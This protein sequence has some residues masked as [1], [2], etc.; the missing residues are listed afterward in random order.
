MVLGVFGSAKAK[1]NANSNSS[2]QSKAAT[3]TTG[4]NRL[5]H[6]KPTTHLVVELGL[7]LEEG[8]AP[9]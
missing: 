2:Q 6:S 8:E 7:V 4:K 9:R 3:L 5:S 1:A